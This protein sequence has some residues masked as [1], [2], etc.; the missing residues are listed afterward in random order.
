MV[1]AV[2]A[3]ARR[4]GKS[5]RSA[6]A[7]TGPRR[8]HH[9]QESDVTTPPA[10]RP[11]PDY[12]RQPT[13]PTVVPLAPEPDVDRSA[14]LGELVKEATV[15][16][17]TL[18]RSEIELAKLELSASIKEALRGSVFFAA[19]AATGLFSLFFFWFMVG[20]IVAIWLPRWAAFTIVFV[21]ML[22]IAGAMV[23]L[24]VKRM[25]KIRKPEQTIAELQQTAE[26][27]KEAAAASPSTRSA[28]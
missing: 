4:A 21:L 13:G 19:A 9:G 11:E 10:A 2:A 7:R 27:L 12:S 24:G 6:R 17:S 3:P 23:F 20:E 26:A 5:G 15:H 28:G 18:V 16:L 25:K 8:Q 1:P 14:S 22:L